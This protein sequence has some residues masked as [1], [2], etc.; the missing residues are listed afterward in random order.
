MTRLR[1]LTLA[2]VKVHQ[3]DSG[4]FIVT[5]NVTLSDLLV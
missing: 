4:H 3:H 1:Y 5:E 2:G